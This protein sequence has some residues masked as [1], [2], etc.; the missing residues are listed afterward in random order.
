MPKIHLTH[1]INCDVE[2]FWKIFFD[3]SFNEK[4][5]KEELQFQEFKSTDRDTPQATSRT[6]QAMPKMDV[7]GP[8]AKLLGSSFRYTE[9]GTREKTSNLWRW[10]TT[11]SSLADKIRNE[12]TMR[13]EASAPGKTRRI[14]EIT[15]EVKMFGVGGLMESMAEK[16]LRDGWEKS[17]LAM[18]RLL[19]SQKG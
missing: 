14:V 4:F 5:Y 18:N 16:T 13:V 2:T 3:P 12:G 10:K 8:V 17:A 7:P 19:A 6:I 11:P 1:E 9:E 15:I